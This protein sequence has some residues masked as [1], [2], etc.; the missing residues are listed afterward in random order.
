MKER[1][2]GRINIDIKWLLT[3]IIVAFLLVFQ[4]FP[5]IYLLFKAFFPDGHF[6]LGGYQQDLLIPPQPA[7][8]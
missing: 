3:G 8:Y 7:L 2:E 4:V 5:M 6:S 1:A